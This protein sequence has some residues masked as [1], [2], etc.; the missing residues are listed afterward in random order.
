MTRFIAVL[1]AAISMSA[2]SFAEPAVWTCKPVWTFSGMGS[3]SYDGSNVKEDAAKASARAN[4]VSDNRGLELDDF[5][6]ADP[7]DNDWHCSQGQDQAGG[8]LQKS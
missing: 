2:H 8:A 6:L 7:R 4:C 1:I 3:K 5:C